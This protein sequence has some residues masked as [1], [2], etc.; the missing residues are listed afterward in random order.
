MLNVKTT[1]ILIGFDNELVFLAIVSQSNYF[2]GGKS[3]EFAHAYVRTSR[4]RGLKSRHT[5]DDAEINH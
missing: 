3:F 2:E 5:F 1:D 4:A